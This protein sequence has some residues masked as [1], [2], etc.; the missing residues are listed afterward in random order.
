MRFEWDLDKAAYNERKHGVSFEEA[1]E[2]FA[3]DAPVYEIYD[4]DHSRDEDRFKST[5]RHDDAIRVISA[6]W[7][8][9]SEE[10]L[11]FEYAETM[12]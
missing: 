9:Q 2:L 4:I 7:A 5:E 8:T 3:T 12:T 11:Y 10:H 6:R 1:K